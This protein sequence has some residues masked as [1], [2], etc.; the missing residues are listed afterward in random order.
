MPGSCVK[1]KFGED[2]KRMAMAATKMQTTECGAPPEAHAD[3]HELT[4]EAPPE[5]CRSRLT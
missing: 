3:P 1:R 2:L 4:L 5:G